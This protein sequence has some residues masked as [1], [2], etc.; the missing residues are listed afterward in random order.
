MPSAGGGGLRRSAALHAAGAGL[1]GSTGR[2]GRRSQGQF[3]V[4]CVRYLSN[5]ATMLAIFAINW[6]GRRLMS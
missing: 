5:Q 6:L 3:V 1:K 4:G 2:T